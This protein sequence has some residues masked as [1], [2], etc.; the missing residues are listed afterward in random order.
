MHK[1]DEKYQ[2]YVKILEEELVPAMGCTEPIA[3]AY[4]GAVARKTLGSLPEQLDIKVSG[5]IIKNV[6]SVVVPNTGGLRGIEAAAAAGVV[7]GNENK[8]LEV[9]SEIESEDI[10]RIKGYLGQA[11]IKVEYQETGHTFD[12]S[13][14]VYKEHSQASVRITDYHTNIVQIEKKRKTTEQ[15]REAS[16]AAN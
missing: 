2:A 8:K 7:C 5:N 16:L 13:V 11:D 14:C 6:K 10:E 9:L 3:I 4:A 15:T 1:S 12:L